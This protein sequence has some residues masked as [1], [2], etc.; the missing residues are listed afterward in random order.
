MENILTV[1]S[2]YFTYGEKLIFDDISFKIKKNSVTAILGSNNCGKTT[3]IKSLSGILLSDGVIQINELP[4][5]PQ[6]SKMILL[7]IGVVLSNLDKQFLFED[8]MSELAF[9][10]ENLKYS[11]KNIKEAIRNISL[12]FGIESIVEEHVSGLNKYQKLLV[13]VA[14]SIIHNPRI[15]FLDD[16][17]VGLSNNEIDALFKILRRLVNERDLTIIFT[18]SNVI[19][20]LPVDRVLVINESKIVMDDAPMEI[21]E[22]ENELSKIGIMIPTMIDLS[23]KLKFY[24]L[25]DK[26]YLNT[27]EVVDKLWP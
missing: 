10:L 14:T 7:N 17:L 21:L 12:L 9:P 8:V 3:L 1:D 15:L 24:D 19:D 5:R 22:K 23:M 11:K 18:T 16:V 27:D 4:L 2:M 20:V 25:V 13:L 26:I 6:N